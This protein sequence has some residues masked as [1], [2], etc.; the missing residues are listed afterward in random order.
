MRVEV[1]KR[2]GHGFPNSAAIQ[3]HN[4]VDDF[5]EARLHRQHFNASKDG[6]QT[7]QALR[8]D[9]AACIFGGQWD[10]QHQVAA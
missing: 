2:V 1:T 10:F 6:A 3:A 4:F 5:G 7:L 9:L 8:Q